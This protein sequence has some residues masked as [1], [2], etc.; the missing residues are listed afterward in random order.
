MKRKEGFVIIEPDTLGDPNLS[1]LEKIMLSRIQGYCKASKDGA[2]S[3]SATDLGKPM[4]LTKRRAC[5]VISNLEK[6]GYL[7]RSQIGANK[8]ELR[9]IESVEKQHS[10]GVSKNST[11]SAEK[12]HTRVSKN[13]TQS[14]EKQHTPLYIE[15][16]ISKNEGSIRNKGASEKVISEYEKLFMEFW[17][18]YPKKVDKKGSFRAFKN[19]PHLKKVF[20]NIISALEIQKKSQQWKEQNG[21]FVPNPT[22]YIHQERWNTVNDADRKN[23]V[24][25]AIAVNAL[26]EWGWL[27]EEG[28]I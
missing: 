16:S 19:I 23:N 21:R 20:P 9:L 4:S 5:D 28:D 17:E 24:V 27:P 7:S 12:Q 8:V 18:L 22:T 13:S 26:R 2:C 6:K 10:E 1:W 14:V 15:G 3:L 11:Q 25:G